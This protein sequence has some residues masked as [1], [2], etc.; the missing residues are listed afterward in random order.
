MFNR[1]RNK[2]KNK[3]FRHM[4]EYDISLD[5][6]RL[7]QL[8][9]AEI[10]DVRN[11]REFEENHLGGSI[12]V[13]EYKID[14]NFEKIIKDKNKVIVLYCTSGNR[15]ENAYKKLKKLGYTQVYNLYGGLDNY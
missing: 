7:K 6:L 9:G 4:K 15:S 1:I 14:K 8:Q 12:N 2:L 13:P 5:E 11:N 10:V 3:F